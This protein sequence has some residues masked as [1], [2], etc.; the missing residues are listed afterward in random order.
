MGTSSC[1][2]KQDWGSLSQTVALGRSGFG[3]LGSHFSWLPKTVTALQGHFQRP[4][5]YLS[6]RGRLSFQRQGWD[7]LSCSAWG[8]SMGATLRGIGRSFG[9]ELAV[10]LGTSGW[11]LRTQ[12]LLFLD[13]FFLGQF[14]W[15]SAWHPLTRLAAG[16]QKTVLVVRLVLSPRGVTWHQTRILGVTLYSNT[17]WSEI[18][19]V[20]MAAR[21][22]G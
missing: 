7:R 17:P 8:T 18:I 22:G 15:V 14:S 5:L 21:T 20:V 12:L 3:P 4:C 11:V 19:R 1:S 13:S 16:P 10:E 9:V 2:R 6:L